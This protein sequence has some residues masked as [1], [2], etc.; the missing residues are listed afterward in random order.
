MQRRT[1]AL[2]VVGV[3]V[4]S[5]LATWFASM[6]IRSPAEVAARTAPPEP[7]AILVPVEER[8][9]ATKVVSRGTAQYGSPQDLTLTRSALKRGPRVV[10]ATPGVGAVLTDGDVVAN[11]S[12][13]PA[14]LLTGSLPSYRDLGPG[15]YGADVRQLEKALKKAGYDPGR[16]DGVYDD[17]TMR[18]I[19]RLYAKRGY[20]PLSASNG[21]LASL[22]PAE[23]KL[24]PGARPSA[25]VQLPAD[26][27]VFVRETPLRVTKATAKV[28]APPAG[29]LLTVTDSVVAVEGTFPVDQARLVKVGTEATIDE[30]DLGISAKG[31]V[32]SVAERPGTDGA[33]GFHVAFE[34]VVP[35]PPPTL[36]GASVRVTVPIKTT[37]KAQLAVPVSAVSLGADGSSR[38][39]RSDG[40]RL[41][42][43]TVQPGLSAE[44]YVAVTPRGRLARGD[45][46]VVGFEK[47]GETR[48]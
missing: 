46:V 38:V 36:V 43:V 47:G 31:E 2:V 42:Y 35:D 3:M 44:G 23:T 22:L 9:L 21:Q 34:V 29:A 10:T 13:R 4:L 14:F 26:E 18:A 7:S 37:R 45:M 17:G 5:S 12:G 6:K 1:L 40:G 48:G 39:Q 19:R 11:V 24:L 28:G 15:M 16:V 30:P 33:D 20:P 41:D 27:V 25:G 32:S 8:V